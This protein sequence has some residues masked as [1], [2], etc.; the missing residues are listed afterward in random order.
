MEFDAGGGDAA[1]LVIAMRFGLR[2]VT[3]EARLARAA[4]PVAVP[5]RLLNEAWKA[6]RLA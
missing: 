3:C 1:Y 2:H 5:I 4:R 6:N